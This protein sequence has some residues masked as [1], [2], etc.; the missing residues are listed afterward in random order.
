MFLLDTDVVVALQKSQ[1]AGKI[2]T[3]PI[4]ITDAVWDELLINDLSN[5]VLQDRESLLRAMVGG[6]TILM[7]ETDEAR[8]V[9]ELEAP[10]SAKFGLGERSIIAYAMHH[11][12]AVA[13]LLDKLAVHRAIEELNSGQVMSLHRALHALEKRGLPLEVSE[14]TSQGWCRS[15]KPHPSTPLV[16]W[17]CG[18]LMPLMS[19]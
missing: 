8:S 6:P 2:R 9:A 12:D 14:A 10:D 3:L 4:I 19:F 15:N 11:P 5:H 18:A 1:L 13:V 7:P 17:S 16:E